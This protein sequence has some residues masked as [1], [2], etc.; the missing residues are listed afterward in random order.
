M[1]ISCFVDQSARR[2]PDAVALCCEGEYLSYRELLSRINRLANA[3]RLLDCRPGWRIAYVAGNRMEMVELYFAASRLGAV[4]APVSPDGSNAETLNKLAIVAPDI[5]ILDEKSIRLSLPIQTTCPSV[6]RLIAF[7]GVRRGCIPYD[8]FME[9]GADTDCCL[10][11]PDDAPNLIFFTSGFTGKPKAVAFAQS[12]F[13]EYIKTAFVQSAPELDGVSIVSMPMYNMA[14]FLS[15]ISTMYYGRKLVIMKRFD[16]GEWIRLVREERVTRAFIPSYQL[17]QIIAHPALDLASMKSLQ[18]LQYGG[19][20]TPPAVVLDALKKL[21]PHVKLRNIYG[22]TEAVFKVSQLRH[23]DYELEAGED[24][25]VARKMLRLN[26][27]GRA[28]DGVDMIISDGS[29]EMPRGEIGEILVRKSGRMLGYVN[30]ETHEIEPFRGEWLHTSDMGYM[31]E[32]GY[33]FIVGQKL[34]AFMETRDEKPLY[35]GSI[36]VL[37]SMID[38]ARL[39]I[40]PSLEMMSVPLFFQILDSLKKLYTCLDIERLRY[41][42]L[43]IIPT[44]IP[45]SVYGLHLAEPADRAADSGMTDVL[46]WKK[47]PF[48]ELR[49]S[50]LNTSPLA[51]GEETR[52]EIL[53]CL[54][55]RELTERLTPDHCLCAPMFCADQSLIGVLSF[56]RLGSGNM[57]TPH[58]R[59]LLRIIANHMGLAITNALEYGRLREQVALG[60]DILQIIEYGVLET[61][62]SG[63]LLRQN[64]CA[65]KILEE[66]HEGRIWAAMLENI[67]G[68]AAQGAS[69]RNATCA[70]RGMADQL[71]VRTVRSGRGRLITLLYFPAHTPGF[72]HLKKLLSKR[73]YEIL[74]CLTAGCSNGEIAQTLMISENTVKFHLKRMFK[75]LGV[76]NRAELLC[77]AY[78]SARE[79]EWS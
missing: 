34:D 54:P 71:C 27:I 4:F 21:P 60:N 66:D 29:R 26:S 2:R 58:E 69:M 31:D 13:A 23:E 56:M 1:N 25:D 22:L 37:P 12:C 28:N 32:N 63:R 41:S 16:A 40:P 8:I 48:D 75:K 47:P 53:D 44:L 15:V 18:R 35:A 39:S 59:G 78:A 38:N 65:A 45:A 17:A 19:D 50:V 46:K 55:I 57:F 64:H 7:G 74:T 42:Y 14:G 72:S 9:T 52:R 76:S 33:V 6:R 30:P 68:M 79:L 20:F 62:A 51:E 70:Y 24:E 73:E 11:C 5:V 10:E 49:V 3:L 36:E 61:D 67:R 43:E 77:K